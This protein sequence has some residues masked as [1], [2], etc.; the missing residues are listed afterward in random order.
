M[1]IDPKTSQILCA[2][3]AASNLFFYLF[4]DDVINLIIAVAM[5]A[6]VVI[7]E[8]ARNDNE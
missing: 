1:T 3:F 2:F 6:T 4:N 8:L 7:L 5:V